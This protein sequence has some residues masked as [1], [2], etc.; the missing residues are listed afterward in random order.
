MADISPKNSGECTKYDEARDYLPMNRWTSFG[1]FTVDN[2]W[3]IKTKLFTSMIA[4]LMF[5]AAALL[6]R[7]IGMIMG[8]SYTFDM[9]C[10]AAD[11]ITPPLTRSPSGRPGF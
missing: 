10:A 8:F 2:S 1:L 4:G 7:L 9:I 3:L 5:M 11:P 6:W